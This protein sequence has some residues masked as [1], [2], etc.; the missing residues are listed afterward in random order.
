M[1][2]L[3]NGEIFTDVPE[4][5]IGFV[6]VITNN[7]NGRRYIGK[8]SFT[9]AKTK[10]IKG[11]KKRS[12]IESDWKSYYGSNK[13][14]QEDVQRL[15]EEN[16]KREIVYLCASK[17]EMTYLELREQIDHRVLETD[18][19]YNDWLSARARKANLKKLSK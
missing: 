6:Y 7:V 9:F 12:R 18:M 8:K 10:T 3:H 19:F 13:S 1:D 17:T 14:L 2:W 16:F 4:G 5:N 11:K 15:G